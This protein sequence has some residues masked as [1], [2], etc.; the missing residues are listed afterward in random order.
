MDLTENDSLEIQ[1]PVELTDNMAQFQGNSSLAVG[2][3]ASSEIRVGL[4]SVWRNTRFDNHLI[5]VGGE[6]NNRH[7][8]VGNRYIGGKSADYVGLDGS[9]MEYGIFAEDI[10][11]LGNNVTLST[12]LRYDLVDYNDFSHPLTWPDGTSRSPDNADALSPRLA[13]AWRQSDEWTFRGSYQR[14]FRTADVDY[15]KTRGRLSFL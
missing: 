4:R 7:F 8:N 3:P 5:A 9:W 11:S 6:I 14:G 12:G 15:L 2:Q 10:I 13:F 1:L